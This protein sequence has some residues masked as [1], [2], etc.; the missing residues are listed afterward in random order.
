M[1]QSLLPGAKDW[2]ADDLACLGVARLDPDSNTLRMPYIML[3]GL[4]QKSKDPNLQAL[5]WN[6]YSKAQQQTKGRGS[7]EMTQWHQFQ[8][9]VARFR[10]LKGFL[11]HGET[12]PLTTLHQ[13]ATWSPGAQ[14]VQVK[15]S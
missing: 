14:S 10:A 13:G 5:H 15:T 1:S 2:T 9:F 12:V 8:E 6:Y 7:D 11:F 3:W 4:S